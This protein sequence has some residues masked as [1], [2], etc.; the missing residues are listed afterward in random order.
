MRH[1][2]Q[3]DDDFSLLWWSCSL[4]AHSGHLA[5]M[6]TSARGLSAARKRK[7]ERG[8]NTNRRRM[9]KKTKS[10][11]ERPTDSRAN[12]YPA[13]KTRKKKRRKGSG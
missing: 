7:S 11:N 8:P 6:P 2:E 3:K 9:P 5:G 1:G 4:A 12:G 13:K 10:E